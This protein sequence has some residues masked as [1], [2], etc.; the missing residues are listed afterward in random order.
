MTLGE[1]FDLS[2]SLLPADLL[3]PFV[4][5]DKTNLAPYRVLHLLAPLDR[6]GEAGAP[7]ADL[8]LGAWPPKDIAA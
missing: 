4:P 2:A 6:L 8:V 5:N 3:G 1:R 7:R